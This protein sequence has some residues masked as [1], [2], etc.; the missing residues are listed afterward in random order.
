MKEMSGKKTFLMI[1]IPLNK[2]CSYSVFGGIKIS[3]N[4]EHPS[5]AL[6]KMDSTEG[7]IIIFFNEQQFLKAQFSIFVTEEGIAISSSDEQSSKVDASITS[8]ELGS[9]TFRKEVHLSKERNERQLRF[10]NETFSNDVHLEKALYPIFVTEG[11]VILTKEEHLSKAWFSIFVTEEGRS[12]RF[13]DEHLENA[14]EPMYSIFKGSWKCTFF[15][16]VHPSN[17]EL[18][19]IVVSEFIVISS[20]FVQFFSVEKRRLTFG[21]F[22]IISTI[23][24][25]FLIAAQ[26]KAVI[27]NKK[28]WN[29]IQKKTKKETL[30]KKFFC[31]EISLKIKFF[32]KLS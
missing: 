9:T 13:N 27:Y 17:V 21:C 6:H 3:S 19:M 2:Y 29:C 30:F 24:I 14:K 25:L 23:S 4:D 31:F 18:I 16:D 28:I 26:D 10:G 22:S 15:N 32:D 8:I 11:P 20:S 7:G 5:K 1:C 12:I